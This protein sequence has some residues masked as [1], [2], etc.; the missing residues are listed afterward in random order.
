MKKIFIFT[1][2]FLY[3]SF[4]LLAQSKKPLTHDVYDSWKSIS[5]RAISNNGKYAAYSL[6]PQE[7]DATLMIHSLPSTD[8]KALERGENAQFSAD[9]EFLVFKIKPQLDSVKAQKR[10]KVRAENLPKDSLGIYALQTGELIKIA[11]VKSFKMPEKAGGWLA[12]QHEKKRSNTKD[13]ASSKNRRQKEE[14]DSLGTELV[15]RNLKTGKEMRFAFVTDYEFAKYAKRFIFASSGDDSLFQAGVYAID[16][17]TERLQPLFRAKGRYKRLALDEQGEQAAFL[18]DLD[19]SKSRLRAFALYYWKTGMDSAVK[20]LDTL[21]AAIPKGMLVSEFFTPR[22]SKDGKKLYYGTSPKPLLPDTTKLPEEI[23][24]VDIWHWRD[25][26]LQPEQVR[27]LS[28]ERERSYLAVFHLD[29]ARAVQ[30]ASKEMATLLMTEDANAEVAI[31]LSDD[32]YEHLKVWEGA[33]VRND[34]YLVNLKDGS[35]NLI[36]ENERAFRLHLS[37]SAKYLLWYSALQNAWLTYNLETGTTANLTAK[38]KIQFANELHDTPSPPDPYGFAGWLDGENT[39]LIYD[40][41]D[42]WLFD[43]TGKTAPKRLTNGREQ[44]IRFRYIKLDDEE[45][46][47]NPNRPMILQAFN[48]RTKGSGYYSF[49]ISTGAAPKALMMGDYAVLELVKA[50]D[51]DALL[52]RKMTVSDFPNFYFTT[53]AFENIVQISDANPQQ[54]AYNWATVELVKWKSFSG[55]MLEGLLYKPEDFDPKKKYPMIVYYYERS[56]DGLHLYTPPAPSRSTVNRTM[57]PSNG[58]L[59]FIPDITYKIGYPGQSA[60]DD[61]VSGVQALLKERKYIDAQRLGLQGQSWG[62][63]QTAYLIT[64]TKKM[65]AAAMAGAPVANMT[66]AYGGIR[67]ESGL[68]RMF[69]YE[70]TQSRIGASLWEKPN[71]YLENSPLFK[72]DKIETPLLIMHN[73]A[74]G[75]VPWYQGIELFMA[76]K[77][78]G[79]PVWMLTYN[80]EAHNLTQRKNMKDL[81]IR[82][83]QFFDHYL[84]GAPMPRWMKEGIPAIEKTINMGYEFAN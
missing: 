29:E 68:S 75:A 32:K 35:R 42:L 55:E 38:M 54:K 64:R 60:Y 47:I 6:T 11:R 33:P 14:N 31:G 56:S 51:S 71:L 44:Y 21:H 28:R 1:L 41:Y 10:R 53:L 62:G 23:V 37:P 25:S 66:S 3:I 49:T 9:S 40:R 13:S 4:P 22:F 30:L 72:A 39:L 36:R 5:G 57:Y 52:F 7:G 80:G 19:T 50:K 2:F 15:L 18:A 69:Q 61:V 70:R 76:L 26:D 63:Y 79:K 82:M 46:S 27:N 17:Q 12:Y 16:L 67:W 8:G 20:L 24:S 84:K 77:R 43:A 34:I 65:F 45:R 59:L 58:Y 78:L 83:Q 73:D 74:D 48:E 81:S